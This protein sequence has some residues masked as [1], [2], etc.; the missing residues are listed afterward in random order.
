M[1]EK[2]ALAI[3]I[4]PG[5][6]QLC[7]PFTLQPFV[8]FTIPQTSYSYLDFFSFN[9]TQFIGFNDRQL[10]VIELDHEAKAADESIF[11]VKSDLY[12]ELKI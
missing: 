9:N 5:V 10:L 4:D 8:A 11:G 2:F 3:Y 7:D 6:L 12:D 1:K